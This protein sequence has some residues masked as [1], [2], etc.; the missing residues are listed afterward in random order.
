[1]HISRSIFYWNIF[2]DL[3]I[4]KCIYLILA[5]YAAPQFSLCLKQ[6]VLAS[7]SLRPPS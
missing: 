1:M 2:A 7:L 4:K 6:A 5:V 3:Q